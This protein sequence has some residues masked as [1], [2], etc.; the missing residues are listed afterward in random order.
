MDFGYKSIRIYLHTHTKKKRWNIQ[1]NKIR[2]HHSCLNY[3]Y[4]WL[5]KSA[6]F[7]YRKKKVLKYA[8][9]QGAET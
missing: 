5:L 1:N 2:T 7:Y 4:L 9:K 8:Y 3:Y 6:I